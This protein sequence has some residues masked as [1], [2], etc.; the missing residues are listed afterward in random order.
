[1]KP[2]IIIKMDSP[3]NLTSEPPHWQRFIKEKSIKIDSTNSP[4][5][6]I[7]QQHAIPFWLTL[8]Y[9][10]AQNNAFNQDEKDLGFDRIYR[11]IL[12]EN[13]QIP[14]AL[15]EDISLTPGVTSAREIDITTS[16]LPNYS[17]QSRFHGFDDKIIAMYARGM[18]TR[19]IQDIVKEL[20]GVDV[21][22]DLISR[23]TE[24]LDAELLELAGRDVAARVAGDLPATLG[25]QLLGHTLGGWRSANIAHADKKDRLH[26][27]SYRNCSSRMRCSSEWSGSNISF[28]TMPF[29]T[30]LG[31]AP[32]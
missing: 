5:D 8:E 10:P 12:K 25:H 2:H 20:Y 24:D 21:S 11:L 3:L 18:T 29:S 31:E 19:D 23:V 17:Q 22:P 4:I 14:D 15:I 28:S 26:E 9:P 1:M 6:L 32:G 27:F 30:S 13:T 7:F 16:P